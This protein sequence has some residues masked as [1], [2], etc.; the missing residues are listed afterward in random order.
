MRGRYEEIIGLCRC[1]GERI[2]DREGQ[3][4]VKRENEG[5]S[6]IFKYRIRMEHIYI[7]IYISSTYI[8]EIKFQN[9]PILIIYNTHTYI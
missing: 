4:W 7:Y 1:G 5:I 9:L 8:S 3:S 6:Q 2:V